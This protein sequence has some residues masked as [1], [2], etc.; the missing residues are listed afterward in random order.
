MSVT[1]IAGG[2]SLRDFPF[3]AITGE[4]YAINYAATHLPRYDRL[5]SF[6]PPKKD[7]PTRNI[8][9]LDHCGGR[10]HN[11]GDTLNRKPGCVA[12]LNHSVYFAVNVA[13]QLGHKQI[14]VLGADQRGNRH[15]YDPRETDLHFHFGLYD[16]YFKFLARDLQPWNGEMVTM[17]DSDCKHL[18][19]MSMEQYKR[20]I[21]L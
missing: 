4:I 20:G 8:E 18:P 21:G 15:W 10:W 12:N 19:N 6:D 14:I 13:I 1:I 3:E 17:V 16:K 5:I 7:Y 2:D 11:H 9:T